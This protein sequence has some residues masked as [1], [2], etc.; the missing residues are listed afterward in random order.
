[1]RERERGQREAENM[2]CKSAHQLEADA[3]SS[4]TKKNDDTEGA[5]FISQW[6]NMSDGKSLQTASC[7]QNVNQI[8]HKSQLL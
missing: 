8:I 5:S 3:V 7:N 2:I 1:M 6:N 4:N